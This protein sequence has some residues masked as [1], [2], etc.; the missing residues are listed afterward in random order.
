MKK[1]AR[2]EK[3]ENETTRVESSDDE[4]SEIIQK[5]GSLKEK[6]TK[7]S[8]DDYVPEYHD[9]SSDDD[10]ELVDMPEKIVK[11]EKLNQKKPKNYMQGTIDDGDFNS[12]RERMRYS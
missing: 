2:S 9:V 4:S 3:P 1:N 12:F 5:K 8:D 6:I 11:K 10:A 7:L